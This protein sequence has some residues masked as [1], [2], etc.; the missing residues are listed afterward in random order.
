MRSRWG[1]GGQTI[2]FVPRDPPA[3][4][5][6]GIVSQHD[7]SEGS[8]AAGEG[9]SAG[10]RADLFA[11]HRL[12]L[13]VEVDALIALGDGIEVTPPGALASG[14]HEAHQVESEQGVSVD[15]QQGPGSGIG[16][17]HRRVC[18]IDGEK[19]VGHAI[20]GARDGA[21]GCANPRP[22]ALPRR[23]CAQGQPELGDQGFQRLAEGS[24]LGTRKF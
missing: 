6:A 13:G 20:D 15:P 4:R 19:T 23:G 1:G 22:F 18:D 2:G 7:Q 16:I 9:N 11:C 10:F 5:Q 8:T 17:D 3:W 24:A 21:A 14:R 12:E